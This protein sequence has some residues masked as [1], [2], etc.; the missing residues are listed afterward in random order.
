MKLI[1]GA[2]CCVALIIV[3]VKILIRYYSEHGPSDMDDNY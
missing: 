1:I 3:L 2:I